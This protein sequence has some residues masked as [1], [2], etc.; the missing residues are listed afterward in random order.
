MKAEDTKGAMKLM[1]KDHDSILDL[2]LEEV[3]HVELNCF[4]S[5]KKKFPSSLLS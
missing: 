2:D 4:F 1:L 3:N 5:K